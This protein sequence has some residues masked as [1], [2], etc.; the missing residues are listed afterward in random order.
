ME[1]SMSD[2]KCLTTKEVARLCRVS[3]ATVKR[4]EDLGVLRSERTNGGH[5][6]FRAEEIA[7]FQRE[8]GLG[9]KYSHGLDSAARAQTRRRDN[10]SHSQSSLFHILIAG[11]ETEAANLLI[12][13]YLHGKSL[14]EVFDDLICSA[15]KRIGELWYKGELTIAQEHLATRAAFNALHKLRHTLP[16]PEM[17]GELAMTCGIEG[18]FH[19]LPPY[20]SQ[21]T[22]EN[23]GWEVM[24]FGANTPLYSLAEEVLQHLPEVVCISGTIMADVERTARDYRI[25]REQTSKLKTKVILGGRAFSE[26]HI[27]KRFPADLYAECFADVTE[28]INILF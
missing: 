20:L 22:I 26:E 9:L 4:W 23:S 7:R 17:S 14:T 18:D 13:A 27:R 25:F 11:N 21:I 8:Q 15:M 10:R 3:D 12:S 5:R 24:N 16:V 19:E 28:F 6:R 2:L 1:K